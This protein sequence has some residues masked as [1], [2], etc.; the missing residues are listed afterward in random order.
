MATYSESQKAERRGFLA[1]IGLNLDA[2]LKRLIL[3]GFVQVFSVNL[4]VTVLVPYY[5]SLGLGSETSGFL[6]SVVQAPAENALYG[7]LTQKDSRATVLGAA[8]TIT[9][10]ASVVAPLLS[11]YIADRY[12]VITSFGSGLVLACLTVAIAAPIKVRDPG[13]EESGQ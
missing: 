10:L 6:G 2:N 12:G 13:R 11:G 1:E 8:H 4:Y 5:R 3:I 7:S 9:Q